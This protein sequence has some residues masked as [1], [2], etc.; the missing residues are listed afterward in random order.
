MSSE[1]GL[2]SGGTISGDL[3]INGDLT[4]NGDGSGAYDEIVNG[5][6]HI[7]SDSGNSTTAFLVEN[8]AGTDVFTVDT[9]NSHIDVMGTNEQ[10]ANFAGS[11]ANRAWI[12]IN[13]TGTGGDHWLLMSSANSGTSTGGGG[14]FA[15][16]N[17]SESLNAM[18]ITST[19]LVGLG[20][21]P[22]LSKLEIT[23][24]S[25]T[26][27]L[28]INATDSNASYMQFTNSTT[29]TGT[30]D[31]FQI[32]LQ[33]DES[34]FI[35][36]KE[37]NHLI[38][39][40]SGTERF[41]IASSGEVTITNTTT[42]STTEGGA[43]RLTSND[44]AT[45]GD[46]H[47]L[48][49]VEF[50]AAD[51]S[52]VVVGASIES[53]NGRGSA[54]TDSENT[55]DLTF[56]T[57]E[58]TTL[59]ERM[60]I[61]GNGKVGIGNVN[62]SVALEVTGSTGL[63][64]VNTGNTTVF[65]IPTSGSYQI[66]TETDDPMDIFT[67]NTKRMRIDNNSRISLS[68]NDNGTGNTLF[69]HDSANNLASGSN[70]NVI[71]GAFA[72]NQGVNGGDFNVS[73]GTNSSRGLTSGSYN[74]A[75]GS[76]ALYTNQTGSH[77]VA[78]GES[79]AKTVNSADSDGTVAIGNYA[80]EVLTEGQYNTAVGYRSGDNVTTGD[81]NTLIG[82]DAGSRGGS[83]DGITTGGSNTAVGYR[84]ISGNSGS[85]LTGDANTAVGTD[86]LKTLS[87]SASYNTAIG[88]VAGTGLTTGSQNIVIGAGSGHALT[89]G[90]YNTI[91]GVDA[92][93]IHDD[94]NNV[95]A[96]GWNAGKNVTA[97]SSIA[98]GYG[99]ALDL[100]SGV[101]NTIIGYNAA[102]EITTGGYNTIIGYE[103]GGGNSSTSTAFTGTENTFIGQQC[104]WKQEQAPHRN[105][106]IGSNAGGTSI[107]GTDNTLVGQAAGY[108]MTS[109]YN[110][111][112]GGKSGLNVTSSPSNTAIGYNAMRGSDSTAGTGTGQNTA[113]GSTALYNHTTG[114][115][116]TTVGYAAGDSLTSGSYNTL[117][118]KSSDGN[119]TANG[120]L[121]VGYGTV[122]SGGY[123]TRIGYSGTA[124]TY[125]T[126]IGGLS[127]SSEQS[128]QTII[129]E[130]GIY[131][132]ISKSQTCNLGGDD[133]DDPTHAT[134]IGKIPRYA[135]I[136][137]CAA[138]VTTLS[139]DANHKL[140]LV[141][142]TDS[143]GTDGTKL[144]NVQSLI[145]SGLAD[146]FS[147]SASD[148]SADYIV[149]D[150]GGTAK[151]GHVSVAIGADSGLSTLDLTSAD[152]YVYLAHADNNHTNGDT[153][154]TTA[155]IVKVLIEYIGLD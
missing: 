79:A 137:K 152:Q 8:N 55:T 23:T 31:G 38:I 128:Y 94:V 114:I 37:S 83:A 151:V 116:N 15:I 80:L 14:A 64:L 77:N 82:Y 125:S 53:F 113:V 126:V 139:S 74:V 84:A 120:Q 18:I 155:P 133:V 39:T 28:V 19:G 123:G 29:G 35:D 63:K 44:G 62:P 9:A 81:K 109:S 46:A 135:V 2:G 141:L 6:L 70:Y 104:G 59:T 52:A 51:D 90:N 148:G 49:I 119:A 86:A 108:D 7:K 110:T 106:Y 69:G 33:S 47:R 117:I 17:N 132:F 127:T 56:S 72:A 73:I 149:A 115:E 22:T 1:S 48:G 61:K 75:V 30:S 4:V 97:D 58:T 26:R 105:T 99:A 65:H 112:I 102:K 145:N 67:N 60:R 57:V 144:N 5:D 50:A 87:G 100:T 154:P 138:I 42:S 91:V 129:G 85:P 147:G 92:A 12:G 36:L 136:T 124:H 76:N 150:S 71:M 78:I 32:G 21:T 88:N 103:A 24:S 43:L 54:W 118:G 13:A 140:K 89:T 130:G 25:N 96:I 10:I 41:R 20:A 142:S 40:T 3:T 134:P 107:G 66:G 146:S 95:V 68:N 11:N 101:Q 45:L 16:V 93:N 34:A 143:T 131:K 27:G 153:D 98:I 122:V 111:F 121:A